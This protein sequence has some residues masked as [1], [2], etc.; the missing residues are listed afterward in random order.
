MLKIRDIK[1]TKRKDKDEKEKCIQ[2]RSFSA[3]LT[4]VG[5]SEII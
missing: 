3:F 1:R 2:I 5:Y 4:I